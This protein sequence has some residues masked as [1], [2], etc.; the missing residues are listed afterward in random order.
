MVESKEYDLGAR[1]QREL[2]RPPATGQAVRPSPLGLT[3]RRLRPRGVGE[4]WMRPKQ[5]E[6]RLYQSNTVPSSVDL[7]A[8]ASWVYSI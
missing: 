5:L 1:R 3:G 8:E 4:S 6:G 2:L 7:D